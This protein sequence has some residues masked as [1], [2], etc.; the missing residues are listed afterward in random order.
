MKRLWQIA[1]TEFVDTIHPNDKQSVYN[2]G[3]SIPMMI[4]I[5]YNAGILTKNDL[6]S[7]KCIKYVLT[8]ILET[9]VLVRITKCEYC[10]YNY[11][12]SEKNVGCLA[13]INPNINNQ[14]YLQLQFDGNQQSFTIQEVSEKL[15]EKYHTAITNMTFSYNNGEWTGFNEKEKTIK[16]IVLEK[17][18]L[19][20]ENI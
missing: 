3:I 5:Y 10:G 15:Y 18:M 14:I 6:N 11:I 17:F 9:N 16:N 8:D 7:C 20:Q 4:G 12:I 1:L 2:Y 19:T 13:G